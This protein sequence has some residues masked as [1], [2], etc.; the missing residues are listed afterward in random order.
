MT[1]FTVAFGALGC[2]LLVLGPVPARAEPLAL[3]GGQLTIG[4]IAE[5]A[6][7]GRQVAEVAA[8]RLRVAH[9]FDAI[10]AAARA[11]MPVYGLTTGVG[12]NKDRPALGPDTELDPELLAA[13]RRFNIGTLHA[14]AAAVG[15]PLPDPVV[16]AAMV[17]RLNLLLTGTSGAQPAV[18]EQYVAFLNC[19]IAPI[20]PERGSIGEAD[21]LQSSHIGLAIAGEWQVRYK[22]RTVPTSEALKACGLKPVALVGKDFLAILGD[23][24]LAVGQAALTLRQVRAWLDREIDVAALALEGLDGNVAPILE[25]VV[26]AHP[27]PGYAAVAERQRAALS[28]SDLWRV[29]EHRPL[30]DPLSFRTLPLVLG[31]VW[32]ALQAAIAATEFEAAHSDDNPSVFLD[33]RLPG[34]P[35]SQAGRYRVASVP[36]AAI[37]PTAGFE[38]IA[39]TQAI[40]RLSLALGHASASISKT[41]LRFENPE[42]TRLPRFLIAPSNT[43][44]GFGSIQKSV[45]ALDAEIRSLATPVSLESATL[46]GNIEDVTTNGPLAIRRLGLMLDQLYPLTSLQL[47]HAA[48]AVDLR[49]GYH[50]GAQTRVLHDGYR[51]LVAFLDKD[52]ILTPDIAAGT[53]YLSE[54]SAAS[55]GAGHE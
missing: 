16:R 50:L 1:P 7:Q 11:H 44:H 37:I 47:M 51:N 8:A 29:S 52:R 28:G 26:A 53:Q 4:E 9:A 25:P 38:S 17:V 19:G 15:D 18:V 36:G 34:D 39:F 22:G 32:D 31:N 5:V 30:Q 12:W 43:G 46:S 33:A 55:L 40:E 24:S 6:K 27:L 14:H 13:S 2:L 49:P 45:A 23:N 48:Q 20:V 10:L 35:D 42:I 3:S 21:I 41:V 54:L